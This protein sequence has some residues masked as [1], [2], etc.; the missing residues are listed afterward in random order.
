[1]IGQ[2]ISHYKILEK[3][4]QGGMG[5]V[6]K[7]EDTKLNRRVALKFLMTDQT[8]QPTDSQRFLREARAAAA[9]NHPNIAA[10]YAIDEVDGQPFIAIEFV[11]GE[12]LDAR[13]ARG[14]LPLDEAIG[15]ATDIAA[16]LRAAHDKTIIH[17]DV[18]SG[19][20][21]V[22]AGRGGEMQAKITDFGLAHVLTANTRLTAEG[23][24]VGTICYMAPEQFGGGQPDGRV[25]VWG[26]AVIMYEML[27]G[28]LPFK[29][30]NV[31]EVVGSILYDEPPA[32][33]ESRSDVSGELEQIIRRGLEKSPGDRY[34]DMDALH[35]DLQALRDSGSSSSRS[36]SLIAR[37]SEA[38]PS[39]AVLPFTCMGGEEENEFFCDGITE[40]IIVALTRMGGL[41]VAARNSAF[42]FKGLTPDI[43]EVGRKL[44]VENVLV[45]SVRRAGKRVR[46]T[47]QLSSAMDGYE[48]WSERYDRVLEDIFDIQDEISQTVASTLRGKLVDGNTATTLKR[49]TNDVDAYNHYLR[50]RYYWNRRTRSTIHQAKESFESALSRDP[51]YALAHSG[52]ADCQVA[53]VLSNEVTP[54]SQIMPRAKKSA[55]R[56]LRIDPTL[57]EAHASLAF[58]TV[59][60]DWDW[61]EGERELER[62]IELD[63]DYAMAYFWEAIF[64]L[65]ATGRLEEAEVR[66][67]QGK[68]LD[69][70]SPSI[71]MGLGAVRFFQGRYD[72]A[73]AELEQC[74]ELDATFPWAN[75]MMGRTQ[76]RLGD[77]AAAESYLR[78]CEMLTYRDGHLGHLFAISGR[79][80]EAREIV[81]PLEA[82]YAPHVTA[83][84]MALVHSGLGESAEALRWLR[85]AMDHRAPQL[86]WLKVAPELAALHGEPGWDA[87]LAEMDLD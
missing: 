48:T 68:K 84:Q 59:I 64:V 31:Q 47:V 18:K 58:A 71:N 50:G 15:I 56:A 67:Q 20:I 61:T 43:R 75:M 17:R 74:L 87:L 51:D 29:G 55:T 49:Y 4:G 12:V 38:T 10:V 41:R 5:V 83:Y 9:L 1:M 37:P 28:K 21:M 78:R 33:A 30:E 73:V 86:V 19:N 62:A 6:Y 13:I 11:P 79:H 76:A 53:L 80:E 57:A 2:T 23:T 35:A 60:Y 77:Y 36:T 39:I 44:R 85:I 24:A 27:C 8:R 32:I 45:G 40:D 14:P 22:T 81:A 54:T 46:I 52:L 7:A 70:L 63:P 42:Q 72:Q 25:D 16:G 82:N 65:V 34:P 26:L 69:P 3:L 66:A